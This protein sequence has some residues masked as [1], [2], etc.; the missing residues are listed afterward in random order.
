MPNTE[1]WKLTRQNVGNL[2]IRKPVG[3]EKLKIQPFLDFKSL[4]K[5]LGNPKELAVLR[6]EFES[7]KI[8]IKDFPPRKITVLGDDDR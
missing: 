6:R 3:I 2:E 4:G 5:Y 7:S 8:Q 1:R